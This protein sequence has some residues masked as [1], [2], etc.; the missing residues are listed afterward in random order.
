MSNVCPKFERGQAFVIAGRAATKKWYDNI[1]T[2]SPK[3]PQKAS[4][5]KYSLMSYVKRGDIIEETFGLVAAITGHIAIVE[6][7]FFDSTYQQ[8]YFRTIEAGID[9]VVHGVLDDT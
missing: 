6:G 9:G 5:D 2:K 1:G 7:K 3:L 8:F 4:Y